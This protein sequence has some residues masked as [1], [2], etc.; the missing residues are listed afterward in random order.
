M[1]NAKVQIMEAATAAL[2][3]TTGLTAEVLSQPVPVLTRQADAFLK[4]QAHGRSYRFVAEVKTVDRFATPALV[5]A[6]LTGL[7]QPPILVA[8]Y[9]TRETAQRCRELNLAFM[10]TAGNAYLEGP[11]LLVWVTGETRPAELRKPRYRAL[12]PAGLQTVFAFLCQPDLI[13]ANY[14]EIARAANVALGTVGPAIKDLEA[15]GLLRFT[16]AGA[17]RLLDP[18]K[19]L[20]EWVAHYH[21]TL[22]PKL[23]P[24]QFDGDTDLLAEEELK[25]YGALW[26]GEVAADKL[27]HTLK[28]AAFT[29]YAR[30]P[31]ARVV[32]GLRLRARPGGRVEILDLFWNLRPEP[33]YP[34]V[35]PAPLVYADLLGT[36]DGR[37]IEAARSVYER[38]IEPRFHTTR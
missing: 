1:Q 27:A 20:Q 16:G 34:D 30:E 37:N 31:I 11:G 13:H 9:V 22:R 28:P 21:T 18:E 7:K 26:G 10:D 35:V 32:A 4:I 24:R 8:P 6:Q 36:Q 15:R 38:I 29:I 23:N 12:T 2:R 3:R 33:G 5:K 17:R 25:Q 14:R 19:L